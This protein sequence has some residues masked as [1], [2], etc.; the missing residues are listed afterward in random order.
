MVPGGKSNKIEIAASLD[1]E[2]SMRGCF[3][4]MLRVA[5]WIMR[6]REFAELPL[7]DKHQIYLSMWRPIHILERGART[8]EYLGI[9]CPSSVLL[10]DD[11]Y[12]VD[13]QNYSYTSTSATPE[14]IKRGIE[15]W[16]PV[17]EQM[18]RVLLTPI[19]ELALTNFEVVYLCTYRLWE[20]D[21]VKD[22]SEETCR[23]AE[24]VLKR[25]SEELHRYYTTELKMKSYSGRLA[26]I[27]RLLNDVDVLVKF[28]NKI[29]ECDVS[30][31]SRSQ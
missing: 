26:E 6:C 9:D 4:N 31:E 20:L 28:T 11:R 29:E 7:G 3:E 22:L 21:R 12:A 13:S 15:A 10:L 14:F 18:N 25:I 2:I 17:T 1:Y 27:I 8:F 24:N 23:I 5:K 16:K 30:K 19:R